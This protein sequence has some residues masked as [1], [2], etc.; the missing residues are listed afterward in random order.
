MLCENLYSTQKIDLHSVLR[1]QLHGLPARHNRMLYNATSTRTWKWRKDIHDMPDSIAR[2]LYISD[3]DFETL[4]EYQPRE[5]LYETGLNSVHGSDE[6]NQPWIDN[7][8]SHPN[9][10]WQN[11]TFLRVLGNPEMLFQ[12]SCLVLITRQDTSHNIP[13]SSVDWNPQDYNI[14]CSEISCRLFRL[15]HFLDNNSPLICS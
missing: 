14:I 11:F 12:K 3:P 4:F 8:N 7:L 13:Y 2:L 6:I 5:V 1:F 9:I 15:F 10:W